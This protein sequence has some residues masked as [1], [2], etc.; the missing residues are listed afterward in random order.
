MCNCRT[1][2]LWRGEPSVLVDVREALI[3]AFVDGALDDGT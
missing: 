3:E 1:G 2:A